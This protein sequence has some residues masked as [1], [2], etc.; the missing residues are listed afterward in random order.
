MTITTIPTPARIRAHVSWAELYAF[1]NLALLD[2][3][4]VAVAGTRTPSWLGRKSAEYYARYLSQEQEIV[5]VTGGARGVDGFA[6]AG[7][8]EAWI[9]VLAEGH[10]P[11]VTLD[12]G[13]VLSPY[14]PGTEWSVANAM[15]R[16]RLIV[17][18]ASVVI[19]VEPNPDGTGG[20]NETIRVAREMGR[21]CYVI[22]RV[23]A[24]ADMAKSK[25]LF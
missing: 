8:C 14:A 23:E 9:A 18:L 21:T 11:S 17:A 1:G 2:K 20:T 4:A 24:V 19:A 12:S 16:V 22:P 5:I 10:P 15:A 13:L 7:S 25:L 3:P 6:H